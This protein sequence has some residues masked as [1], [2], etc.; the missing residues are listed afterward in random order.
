MG[1]AK[2]QASRFKE[3]GAL[4]ELALDNDQHFVSA[5]SSL[6]LLYC[7][8]L[9]ERAKGKEMLR[10]A[11][12]DGESQRIPQ[13]DLLHLKAVNKQFV[14]EKPVG[15]LEEYRMMQELCPDFMPPWNNSGMILRSLGRYAQA[16]AMFE[17]AAAVAPRNS[18]P[19]QNMYYTQ[20]SLLR[21]AGAAEATARRFVVLSPGVASSHQLALIRQKF[22]TIPVD[23]N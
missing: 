22:L 4:L 23:R 8:F 5:R 18:I 7:Q 14:D 3:A 15:A 10:R 17:K 1:Q 13:R 19:L 6:G 9:N 16:V 20:L 12:R 21:D 2:W 11:L